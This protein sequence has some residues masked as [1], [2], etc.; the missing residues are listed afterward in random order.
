MAAAGAPAVDPIVQ[1]CREAHICAA[2]RLLA[3]EVFDQKV[4][5]LLSEFRPVGAYAERGQ[6]VRLNI[7]PPRGYKNPVLQHLGMHVRLLEW[8]PRKIHLSRIRKI[9]IAQSV[10][11]AGYQYRWRE[12]DFSERIRQMFVLQKPGFINIVQGTIRNNFLRQ[13]G[14]IFRMPDKCD[15]PNWK[16]VIRFV[17]CVISPATRG[18]VSPMPIKRYR[19]SMGPN[20]AL[21][22]MEAGVPTEMM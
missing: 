19:P 8:I 14:P 4:C 20:L 9:I 6:T 16:R 11:N 13:P 5:A 18:L 12:L 1:F 17:A 15:H 3:F 21:A 10:V 22:R 7:F 2:K